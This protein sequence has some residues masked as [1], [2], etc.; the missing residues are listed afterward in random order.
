[1]ILHFPTQHA[2]VNKTQGVELMK[3]QFDLG[4]YL[5]MYK[6][7]NRTQNQTINIVIKHHIGKSIYYYPIYV[8]KVFIRISF[9][10]EAASFKSI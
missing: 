6:L 3:S 2:V 4:E 1:M 10:L 9:L 5:C 7:N 8:Q